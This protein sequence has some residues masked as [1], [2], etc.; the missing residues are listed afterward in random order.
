ICRGMQVL[1]VAMGGTLVQ[2]IPSQVTGALEHSVP[3]P[4]AASAHEVW[5]AKGSK[6]SALLADHMED[7]E[8]CHVNS[9]HHQ[10]VKQVA[11]GIPVLAICRGMQVL[12]VAMGGTLFQDIPSQVTGALE[13]SVPQP[14]FQIAHEVWVSTDSLLSTL[15]ADHME[16]GETCH[17]NSRHHQSVKTVADGFE[18]TA[19]SPD[20]V[21]EAMEKPGAPFCVAV[22][23]H[24]ENFWRTGEF[25]E[26]FEGLV[27]AAS[28]KT[29]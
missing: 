5:I 27:K 1:N 3:Q 4:R 24:P 9:R 21:I 23:W 7:G 25:R 11:K 26:L 17:V 15:L 2:D 8:T 6:L 29:R 13:H 18:V 12:N 16:D 10:S 22:Q 19:T 14:R 28:A 20:G